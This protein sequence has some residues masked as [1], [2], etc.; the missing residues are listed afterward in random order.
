VNNGEDIRDRKETSSISAATAENGNIKEELTSVTKPE[1]TAISKEI[2]VITP[3]LIKYSN[4]VIVQ[5]SFQE[6]RGEDDSISDKAKDASKSFKQT[7]SVVGEK[8]KLGNNNIK[9]DKIV[10]KIDYSYKQLDKEDSIS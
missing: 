6:K 4:V 9:K 2:K 3:P 5:P 8:A 7:V 10:N 1:T